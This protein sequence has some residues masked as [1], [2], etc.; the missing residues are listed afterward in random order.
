MNVSFYLPYK[1]KQPSLFT[2]EPTGG[3]ERNFKTVYSGGGKRW[4]TARVI[5]NGKGLYTA[6]GCMHTRTHTLYL[7][8]YIY[9]FILFPSVG[10]S[11]LPFSSIFL[12]FLPSLPCHT[13]LLTSLSFPFPL[14]VTVTYSLLYHHHIPLPFPLFFFFRS[15]SFLRLYF[16]L[17]SSFPSNFTLLLQLP[18]SPSLPRV[19]PIPLPFSLLYPIS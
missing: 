2:A 19:S 13:S 10:F 17:F 11:L 12:P 16:P 15:S 14:I 6:W 4:K 8:L 18:S 9:P 3:A 7:S 5:R 1:D